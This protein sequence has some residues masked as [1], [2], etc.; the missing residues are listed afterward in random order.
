MGK[1]EGIIPALITPF[2]ENGDI[3][4]RGIQNEIEYLWEYGIKNVFICGSYGAFPTMTTDER[5]KVA[6]WAVEKCKKL[7]MK[8]IVQVGS[9]SINTAK[10]LA[11]HAEIIGADAIS[12]VVPFYYSS[13]FY[14]E[15]T[16]LRYYE[17]LTEQVSIDVHCYNNPGT[18][19]FN[20]SPSMLKKLI[21]IGVNGIKD[22]GS[23]MGRMLEMLT[24][25][26]ESGEEFDYYP[27]STSSLITG[28]LLGAQA[29]ISGVCLS[30][31]AY[32]I[33]IYNHVKLNNFKSAVHLYEQVMKIRSVL[34]AKSGRAIATYDILKAKGIDVGTCRAPW[35]KLSK[36]DSEEMIRKLVRLGVS[37]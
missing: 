17:A 18:T 29:C 9:P 6:S 31:P 5:M 10:K 8:S 28:F 15:D 3:Y 1:F 4:I 2:D 32:I 34:G 21:D 13:T 26:R 12:S 33:G 24:V 37:V 23:D 25:A 30:V 14:D 20:I 19:G 22:G 7:D 27:S 36:E 35:Q 11:W 16:F